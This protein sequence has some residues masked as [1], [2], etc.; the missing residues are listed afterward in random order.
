M[1]RTIYGIIAIISVVYITGCATAYSR[2]GTNAQSWEDAALVSEQRLELERQSKLIADLE[3]IIQSG[4]AD[5]A[6][7]ERYLGEFETGNLDLADWLRRVDEFV[8]RVITVQRELEAVQRTDS[9]ENAA[10]R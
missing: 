4:A 7:A 6:E 10:E 2:G 8:R 9:G 1:R 5:L 3:R